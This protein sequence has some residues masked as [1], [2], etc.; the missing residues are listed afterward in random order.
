ME[1]IDDDVI[2][3]LSSSSEREEN[4]KTKKKR[5]RCT[6]I[7]F[8][9]RRRVKVDDLDVDFEKEIKTTK[10]AVEEQKEIKKQSLSDKSK[11]NDDGNKDGCDGDGNGIDEDGCGDQGDDDEYESIGDGPVLKDDL[12]LY[13]EFGEIHN[14]MLANKEQVDFFANDKKHEEQVFKRNS[15]IMEKD[16]WFSTIPQDIHYLKSGVKEDRIDETAFAANHPKMHGELKP[17]QKAL[18]VCMKNEFIQI[19]NS[20]CEEVGEK[21]GFYFVLFNRTPKSYNVTTV[22]TQKKLERKLLATVSVVF[23]YNPVVRQNMTGIFLCYEHYKNSLFN[24]LSIL[25]DVGVFY[26]TNQG[27]KTRRLKNCL[28]CMAGYLR[29]DQ[30]EKH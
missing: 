20:I 22:T 18:S 19:L 4:L 30:L 9:K 24:N 26:K 25:K 29:I 27:S 7:G 14:A 5:K 15:I 2:E 11:H 10:Q 12:Q 13:K 28:K 16:D 17:Y 8:K 3:I 6:E 21:F 1:F 23:E